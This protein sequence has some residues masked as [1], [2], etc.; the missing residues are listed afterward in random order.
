MWEEGEEGTVKPRTLVS[1]IGHTEELDAE[2]VPV[3]PKLQPF[4][5]HF[6]EFCHIWAPMALF[7]IQSFFEMKLIYVKINFIY[8]QKPKQKE[9]H[10]PEIVSIKVNTMETEQNN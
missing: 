9:Y 1:I 4:W 7:T 5:Y 2:H 3:L 8:Q 6:D 10:L